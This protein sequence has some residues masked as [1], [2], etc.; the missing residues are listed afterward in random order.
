MRRVT[1]AEASVDWSD[2]LGPECDWY[3]VMAYNE[4]LE[5][6]WPTA[7]DEPCVLGEVMAQRL[8]EMVLGGEV[9]RDEQ[10]RD[11]VQA[12]NAYRDTGVIR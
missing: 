9:G 5:R 12:A 4:A 2:E 1:L 10:G 3:D 11:W 6:A 8:C 7:N